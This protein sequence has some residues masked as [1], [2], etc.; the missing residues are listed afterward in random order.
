LPGTYAPGKR[1]ELTL[2]A[3]EGTAAARARPPAGS[4]RAI[5]AASTRAI[6]AELGV[7]QATV[8]Y[9][10]G[11]KEDLYRAVME[12]LT[13]DLVGQVAKWA[14]TD[15]R[16]RGDGRLAGRR[17]VAYRARAADQPRA[18]QRADDAGAADPQPARGRRRSRRW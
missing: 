2:A 4:T 1:Q 12:Q 3:T 17:P 13:H 15:F 9:T 11:T 8:H 10:F 14:P 6:A 7:A 5:A 16:V 18:A